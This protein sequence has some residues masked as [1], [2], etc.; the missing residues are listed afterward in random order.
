MTQGHRALERILPAVLVVFLLMFS[1]PDLRAQTT[2]GVVQGLV[3]DP[4]GA[5]IPRA[6]VTASKDGTV[7]RSAQSDGRGR[8]IINGLP[9]GTY[10]MH[11]SA[12]GFAAYKGGEF[13]VET[14]RT[15]TFNASLVLR[16][17]TDQVTVAD[18]AA[19]L[20]D[21]DPANNAGALVLGKTEL[22]ALP[23]DPDDLA[24]DLQALAGPA[25]GPNGD[26][27][28]WTDS[29]RRL[30]AKQSIR[31]VR[32][33]QNPF[34]AQSD[35]PGQG[36]IEVFTKPGSEDYHGSLLYQFSDAALNSR[37]TFVAS[38]PPY[39]RRQWEGELSGAFGKKTSFST[40]FE[41]RDINENAFVNALILD[42]SLN[43]MP[44]T[45]AVV[46][47]LGNTEI[48]FKVDRQLTANHTL[49]ARYTFARDASDNQGVGGFSLPER[50]YNVRD[51]EDTFQVIETGVLNARTINETRFRFRRQTSDQNGGVP[52]PTITVLDAFSTGGS[53]V[54]NSFN[55]QNRFEVQNF[56]TRVSGSHTVRWGGLIRGISLTDQSMVNYVG[57]YTFTSLASY[58]L[59]LLG[60][61]NGLTGPQIRVT[62][63][64]ASQFSLSAGNPLASLNQID[65]GVYG[66]DDWR[67]RPNFTLSAGLRVEAQ[68]HVSGLRDF[69]PRLGFA[70]APG[71]QRGKTPKNVVRGGVGL[72]YDRLSESLTL[73]ALRQNGISQQQFL[74]PNPDFYP[75]VPSAATLSGS[76]QP[77]TIR[78][79][80]S[81]WRAPI[82]LQTSLGYERQISK[83]VTVATN[84]V[85]S[86]GNHALRSRNI[87]A[88]VNNVFPYTSRNGIYLYE[89]SGRYRQ[90]QI[91]TNFNLRASS[92]LTFTGSYTWGNAK[93][94]TDGA[95]SFPANQ[96][97]LTSE[98]GRAG[99]D[100]RHR[101]QLNGTW[102]TKWGLRFSPFLTVASGRPFNIT[103][104]K[105]LNADGLYTDRPGVVTDP[106]RS[107][108]V[109]TP[110]GAFDLAPVPG[111]A[112]IPR[113]YGN[114]PGVVAANLR[115]GKTIILRE[116]SK[117]NGDP[118]QML[119]SVNAR[120][121][122]NHPNYGSPTGNLSSP[123]FGQSLSL[124]G[125][126]NSSAN[127]RLDLQIRFE[128]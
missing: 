73:T 2:N 37:N 82:M 63:G 86:I 97:D 13:T 21:T 4:S 25:A 55:R 18:R 80:D 96:Y 125:G 127:R 93:S 108:V 35:R 113:N 10:A 42:P 94:N 112:I 30:P 12:P 100:V 40:D 17:V 75:A 119:I 99:F 20:I 110:Y 9:P 77:Q 3:I 102:N 47:P 6:E 81:H 68:S 50:A 123:L 14:G 15:F 34:A 87:N 11:V 103:T 89:T 88:P 65:F 41:R 23:D 32:V 71:P 107:S 85:H 116:P 7:V 121:I 104:G 70:W 52:G 33:N 8:Y 60:I 105:D 61:Q 101:V 98:Y 109:R 28:M 62:G 106:A 51:S 5:A 19:A 72:F 44:F 66:Q 67:M 53:P 24:A 115:I 78:E 114:S 92:K 90:D 22:E 26:S 128:F 39:Q 54:G 27:S 118:L 79:T 36:R 56:T 124:A 126:N 1:Q 57:A 95:G 84:Y 91:V 74:I 48:N 46:T 29:R 16:A 58:R 111:Q 122:L 59:T 31:E 64:G 76:E 43:A 83:T 38:K 120:N 45:T 69:G 117:K 49:S